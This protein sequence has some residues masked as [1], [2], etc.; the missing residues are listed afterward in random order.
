[1]TVDFSNLDASTFNIVQ[2]ESGQLFSPYYLDQWPAWY[3]GATFALAYSEAAVKHAQ[4]HLLTL[5]P[6]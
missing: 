3:G 4:A 6:K 2:G 1:M 5:Q